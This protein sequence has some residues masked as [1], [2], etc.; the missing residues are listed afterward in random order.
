MLQWIFQTGPK[1]DSTNQP[2]AP[3][4][5]GFY[6]PEGSTTAKRPGTLTGTGKPKDALKPEAQCQNI[7]RAMLDAAASM[8]PNWV[9]TSINLKTNPGSPPAPFAL[10]GGSLTG[11]SLLPQSRKSFDSEPPSFKILTSILGGAVNQDYPSYVIAYDPASKPSPFDD[12]INQST[13]KNCTSCDESPDCV[14][15]SAYP[16]SPN[17]GR[18]STNSH[19]GQQCVAPIIGQHGTVPC[20]CGSS[21]DC[22]PIGSHAAEECADAETG[23]PCHCGSSTTCVSPEDAPECYHPANSFQCA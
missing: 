4:F 13:G 17:G 8:N 23:I 18:P 10:P 21:P 7:Y 5:M 22:Q 2:A 14:P 9:G 15:R 1:L 12:C 16:D 19:S 6:I 3:C 20:T 11:M